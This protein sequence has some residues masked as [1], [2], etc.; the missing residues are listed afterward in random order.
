MSI[1]K[2][3]ALEVTNRFPNRLA[4]VIAGALGAGQIWRGA[5][6]GPPSAADLGA[7]LNQ[8]MRDDMDMGQC[9][10]GLFA[11][12]REIPALHLCSVL[13]VSYRLCLQQCN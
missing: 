5:N 6:L 4:N 3:E 9:N 2:E 1:T 8:E 12:S 7:L 13:L 10:G 11:D